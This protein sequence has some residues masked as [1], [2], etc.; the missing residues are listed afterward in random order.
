M[1][2]SDSHSFALF[3]RNLVRESFIIIC[4]S[5]NLF[6]SLDKTQDPIYDPGLL[7]LQ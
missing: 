7:P 3:L 4:L 2:S 6:I 5:S 1:Y